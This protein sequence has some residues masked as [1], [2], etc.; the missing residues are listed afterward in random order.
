MKIG[1]YIHIGD[2]SHLT[3]S[4]GVILDD[5]SGFSQGVRSYSASS[6][7]SGKTLTSSTVPKEYLNLQKNLS[8]LVCM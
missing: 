4:G 5:V 3:C 1:S 8:V 7:F 6:H 2:Y